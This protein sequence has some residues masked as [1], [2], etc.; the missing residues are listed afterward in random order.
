MKNFDGRVYSISDIIEWNN[1]GLLQLSADFQRRAV[2]SEKAK[3]YLI[4]TIIRGKPIPKILITQDLKSG[5]NIRVV[6]DGQQ[7]LRAILGFFEGSFKLS[8]AHTK[9]YAGMTFERLPEDIQEAFLKYEIGVDIL[10]E[11]T[12]EELLDVF[13]RLNSYT[14]KLNKQ[15]LLNATYSGYFKQAAY[16]C[17]LKYVRY[18]VNASI[19]T[20]AAVTRMAEAEL[21]ADLLASLLGG[22]QTNKS[23]ESYYR[24]YEDDED[25]L[26]V[27]IKQFDE[28][29]TYI[30]AIY[31]PEELRGTNWSR[32]HLFYT[33]FNVISHALFGVDNL[34]KLARFKL[35]KSNVAKVRLALDDFSLRFD[36]VAE[37]I[38]EPKA[39]KDF[40]EFIERSRRGTTDTKARV[41]RANFASRQIRNQLVHS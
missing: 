23:I 2:W 3:S 19:L 7:R 28:V 20:K 21:A 12:Y 41:Y 36:Y 14:V 35:N 6:V 40:K 32:S 22:V 18:F 11:M 38:H 13:Q 1:N 27:A 8:R 26:Q 16:E 15:E 9:Q 25:N 34:D 4:D 5:R 31:P 10:F 24:D 33:L 17:G 39:P 37:M 30:G 29:M